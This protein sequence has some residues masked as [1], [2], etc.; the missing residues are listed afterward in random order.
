MTRTELAPVAAKAVEGAAA[1]AVTLTVN[2][3]GQSA[4]Q[5]RQRGS[6]VPQSSRRRATRS[7]V[8]A[9]QLVMGG[10]KS[11]RCVQSRSMSVSTSSGLHPAMGH[12]T[13][14][15]LPFSGCGETGGRRN[16]VA[17]SRPFSS[18][19]ALECRPAFSCVNSSGSTTIVYLI[20]KGFDQLEQSG[21]LQHVRPPKGVG[22][23]RT[24]TLRHGR[25]LRSAASGAS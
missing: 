24:I 7:S 20:A 18:G 6:Y 25:V 12:A 4:R 10:S 21:H 2:P 1:S 23:G 9:R 5:T 11:P 8:S 15:A 17:A 16:G 3:T 14:A 13:A 22:V 19:V